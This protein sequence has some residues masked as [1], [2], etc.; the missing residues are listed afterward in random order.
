MRARTTP[1]GVLTFALALSA[2][3]L[4]ACSSSSNKPSA[5]PATSTS[6][7]APRVTA[8][9]ATS[10]VHLFVTAAVL[11]VA[12]GWALYASRACLE[13][14]GVG[15]VWRPEIEPGVEYPPDGSGTRVVRPRPGLL[16]VALT[17]LAL[18]AFVWSCHAALSGK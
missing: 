18:G 13:W 15:E 11:L 8:D 5:A 10:P 6:T 12:A 3:G 4:G 7:P 14:Q 2:I 17:V 16:P 1:V 9:P